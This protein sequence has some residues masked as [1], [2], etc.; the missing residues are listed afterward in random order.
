MPKECC[1]KKHSEISN[2]QDK[3]IA[4]V[5]NS[6]VGKST[7]FNSLCGSNQRVMNVA[8]VTVEVTKGKHKTKNGELI[9]VDLPGSS[10]LLPLTPDEEVTTNYLLGIDGEKRPD[11][12][13][14][15]ASKTN[16]LE[17][18][19]FYSQVK[20][21]GIP[22]IIVF[23]M[24][25]LSKKN[26]LDFDILELQKLLDDPV[27][28]LDQTKNLNFTKLDNLIVEKFKQ[29]NKPAKIP[30]SMLK[31]Y[32][33][34]K[35]E[36]HFEFVGKIEKMALKVVPKRKSTLS[37]KIDKFVL[38]KY[39]S[40][41]IFLLIMFLIFQ[42]TTTATTFINDFI[43]S[44]IH[45]FLIDIS[46]KISIILNYNNTWLLDF[47]ND[48]IIE[49]IFSVITFIIPISMTFLLLGIMEGSGYLARF[50]FV[51]DRLLRKLGLD[52][53]ALL[54]II[55]GFGCNLPSYSA[56]KIMSDSR[57]RRLV[58]YLVPFTLCSARLAVFSV[59][60]STT[61]GHLGG[62]VLWLM[63]VISIIMIILIGLLLRLL[64]PAFRK[65]QLSP[66]ITPLPFYQ[67]PN[68]KHLIKFTSYKLHD[69][70]INAGKVIVSVVIIIWILQVIPA[71]SNTNNE[72]I[73]KVEN[74]VV[75]Q[76]IV[77][78]D[79]QNE[80][81]TYTNKYSPDYSVYDQITSYITPIFT[82]LGFGDKH[83]SSALISGFV[84]KE[85]VV[86]TLQE[87]YNTDE[88]SNTSFR[89]NLNNS[90]FTAGNTKTSLAAFS[91]MLF[92]LL[93]T[94]CLATVAEAKRQFGTK[95][96][97]QSV[98]LNLGSAYILSLLIF[99]IGSLFV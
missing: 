38:S 79:E 59:I 58:G 72:Q 7:L 84:A 29:K 39:F 5:G 47:I 62:L 82:P 74:P 77:L 34:S 78:T 69:F 6:N 83:L 22:I 50:S 95:F 44:S 76:S 67:F 54:P 46:N 33:R 70:I 11:L 16:I 49:G 56:S 80:N 94:P 41:P 17:G 64:S 52:G 88:F 21:L 13:I 87:S 27:I 48:A 4:L 23:T 15:V 8:G 85:V 57:Q 91:F 20:D 1:E 97:F 60:S 43:T 66:F 18:A 12:I 90:F 37:D 31:P 65:I 40:I 14:F 96:M 51:A 9:I 24:V 61:F 26:S 28:E 32:L 3:T 93:Y 35:M 45:D 68:F 63:Y 98:A 86:G 25:D 89:N 42:L 10:S 55:I 71:I 81:T 30:K 73:T 36:H 53:K 75:G 99:Q 19:Y 2:V 92:V